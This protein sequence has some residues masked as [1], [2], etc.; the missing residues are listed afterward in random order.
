MNKINSKRSFNDEYLKFVLYSYLLVQSNEILRST[1]KYKHRL[2]N[3]VN[4]MLEEVLPEAK[5]Y[6]KDNNENENALR[7]EAEL[8]SVIEVLALS[9]LDEVINTNL[10]LRQYQLDK[11]NY[12]F[13]IPKR[14]LKFKNPFKKIKK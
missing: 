10:I 13:R 8:I 9:S 4:R 14:K 5:Q 2:K 11:N 6:I 3:K 7:I 12:I 1:D